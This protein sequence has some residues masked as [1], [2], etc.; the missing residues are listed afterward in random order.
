MRTQILLPCMLA[1]PL[2][3]CSASGPWLASPWQP[4][5]SQATG[6]EGAEYSGDDGPAL[7]ANSPNGYDMGSPGAPACLPPWG[8]QPC[9]PKPCAPKQ[10]KVIRVKVPPQKVVVEAPQQPQQQPKQG[11]FNPPQEVIL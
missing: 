7:A 10:P 5:P 3:G 4:G 2:V 11:A 8:Q 9:P 6:V 1:I